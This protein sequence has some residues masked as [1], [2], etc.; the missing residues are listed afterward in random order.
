[1]KVRKIIYPL[2][3]VCILLAT[4]IFLYSFSLGDATPD[5]TP[6]L[7]MMG[8]PVTGLKETSGTEALAIAL[9]IIVIIW[10]YRIVSS[11]VLFTLSIV[12]MVNNTDSDN[13]PST[14]SLIVSYLT[15]MGTDLILFFIT[16]VLSFLFFD[17]T[18]T[19]TIGFYIVFIIMS[20]IFIL[21]IISE[22]VTTHGD[23]GEA[24]GL[25]GVRYRCKRFIELTYEVDSKKK[26]K[27][28]LLNNMLSANY[29]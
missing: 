19:P 22:I 15:S 14:L 20:V 4:G 8:E 2:V 29:E 26:N 11:I 7:A 10:I 5:G 12:F 3:G 17:L 18:K 13:A 9:G 16:G 23:S 25:L 21:K 27:E 24:D 28:K 6:Y 1:M